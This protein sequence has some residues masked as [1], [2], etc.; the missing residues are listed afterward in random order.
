MKEALKQ[1]NILHLIFS[2]IAH[3][4]NILHYLLIS[5]IIKKVNRNEKY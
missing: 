1:E 4:E 5:Y 3:K 2:F